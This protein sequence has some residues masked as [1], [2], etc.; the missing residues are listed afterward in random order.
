MLLSLEEIKKYCLIFSQIS[1][2]LYQQI[3]SFASMEILWSTNI[4]ITRENI[5]LKL[6]G[7]LIQKAHRMI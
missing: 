6:L 7:I 1:P 5:H 2:S 3:L 4:Q